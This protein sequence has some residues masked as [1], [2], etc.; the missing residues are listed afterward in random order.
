M[1]ELPARSARSVLAA[2]SALALSTTIVGWAVAVNR[3]LDDSLA[4]GFVATGVDILAFFPVTWL[5]VLVMVLAQRR[6]RALW[7][8]RATAAILASI[9]GYGVVSTVGEDLD[10]AVLGWACSMIAAALGMLTLLASPSLREEFA[11]A[12]AYWTSGVARRKVTSDPLFVLSVAF[13]ILA[14]A[15]WGLS[16][17]LDP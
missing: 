17:L 9:A 2:G 15:A 10:A 4:S 3:T 13:V 7:P 14:S 11:A 1:A 16:V 5:L 8:A 6:R 12:D